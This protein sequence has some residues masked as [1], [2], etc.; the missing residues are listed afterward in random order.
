[1][2]STRTAASTARISH[3]QYN[4]ICLH[5]RPT[6]SLK[7][8][9]QNFPRSWGDQMKLACRL[10]V[11]VFALSYTAGAAEPEN[12]PAVNQI[13]K[14]RQEFVTAKRPNDAAKAIRPLLSRLNADQLFS[15][16]RDQHTGL[17]LFAAWESRKLKISQLHGQQVPFH[18]ERFLG[19]VEG[20]TRLQCPYRWSA[21]LTCNSSDEAQ[22]PKFIA[23]RKLLYGRSGVLT[24]VFFQLPGEYKEH[25][26]D[27]GAGLKPRIAGTKF[28]VPP[29]VKLSKGRLW[30]GT[31]S[32]PFHKNFRN[33]LNAKS[34]EHA[35]WVFDEIS[36]QIGAKHSYVAIFDVSGRSFPLW[37]LDNRTGKILWQTT[38]WGQG[39]EENVLEKNPQWNE[40]TI[41]GNETLVA[42]FGSGVKSN[43]L[44]GFSVKM[45][46][47]I[48]RFSTNDWSQ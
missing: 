1:M 26:I 47:S 2:D 18:P 48:F 36:V 7:M 17:A 37:C 14:L 11:V 27:L 3:L 5:Y 43:Y 34:T 21:L 29:D 40:V 25:V 22:G 24:D 45:G 20:R 8:G 32:I 16:R 6:L 9:D 31:R 15:L 39:D 28:T 12:S 30:S 35:I 4:D 10:V 23:S 38:V 13:A 42:V 41:V 33:T 19:L 44:E 46:E